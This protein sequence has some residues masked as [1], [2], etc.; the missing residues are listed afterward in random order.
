[1][2]MLVDGSEVANT[3][4]V[5]LRDLRS[6][7]LHA[8]DRTRVDRLRRDFQDGC[9]LSMEEVRWLHSV[10]R[11]Y[12][13][14]LTELRSARERA[15]RTNTLR[16]LGITQAEMAARKQARADAEDRQRSDLGF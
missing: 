16:L 9:D 5:M 15:Q 10:C 13:V 2:R 7:K 4:D 6:V 14:Q 12:A 3:V 1:M 8:A 11:R